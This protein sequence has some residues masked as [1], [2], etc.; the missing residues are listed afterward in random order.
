MSINL[1]NFWAVPLMIFVPF[2]FWHDERPVINSIKFKEVLNQ[3]IGNQCQ[4]L[5]KGFAKLGYGMLQGLFA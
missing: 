1:S 3:M 2:H 4:L 5:G